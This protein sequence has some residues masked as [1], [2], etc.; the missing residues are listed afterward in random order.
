[1]TYEEVCYTPKEL[2]EFSNLYHSEMQGMSVRVDAK[3]VG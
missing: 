3:G 1:M 2:L